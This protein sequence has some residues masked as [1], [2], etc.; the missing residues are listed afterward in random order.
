MVKGLLIAAFVL[1]CLAVVAVSYIVPNIRVHE[2]RGVSGDQVRVET[3]FGSVHVNEQKNAG[4]DIANFPIY[5]GAER[6]KQNG[7][8]AVV[9][10]DWGGGEKQFSISAAEFMTNDS[11]SKVREW[12]RSQLPDWQTSDKEMVHIENGLKRIISVK[13]RNG[14]TRIGIATVGGEPAAN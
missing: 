1:V 10:F 12:Y 11:V 2:Q 8:G 13:E 4:L 7:G 14:R 3:P 5:P 6:V 9:D